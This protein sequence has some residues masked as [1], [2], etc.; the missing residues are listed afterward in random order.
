MPFTTTPNG[1]K[2]SASRRWL[3]LRL[4][5]TCVARVFG[6]VKA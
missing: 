3:S 4:M 1:A 6:V 5:N 2:P